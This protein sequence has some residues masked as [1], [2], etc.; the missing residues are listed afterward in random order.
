MRQDEN[1]IVWD[2]AA[3]QEYDT[4]DSGMFAPEVLGPTVDR[5]AELAEGGPALEFAIGTGRVGI[6]LRRRGVPVVGIELSR[7]MVKRLP[8]RLIAPSTLPSIYKDSEPVI[9]PLINRPLPSVACSVFPAC[10]R[11][12]VSGTCAGGAACCGSGAE[13]GI[14]DPV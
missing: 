13:F 14:D 3:A 6:P 1:E 12:G 11:E 7:P 2:D 4:P 8:G 10:V 9:S 5:L